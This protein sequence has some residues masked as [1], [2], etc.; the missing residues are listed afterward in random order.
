MGGTLRVFVTT[1]DQFFR[2]VSTQAIQTVAYEHNE[3][4]QLPKQP[5]P[6]TPAEGCLEAQTY[7]CV[8]CDEYAVRWTGKKWECTC[9]GAIDDGIGD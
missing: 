9:C 3:K 1:L 4:K 2:N 5:I 7:R 6:I 8:V